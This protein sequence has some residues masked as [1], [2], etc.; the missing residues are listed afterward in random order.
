MKR[1]TIAGGVLGAA[2]AVAPAFAQDAA[3]ARPRAA[4]ADMRKM[5]VELPIKKAIGVPEE[6]HGAVDMKVRWH[7]SF[8]AA[9]NAA[10]ASGRPVLLFQ[11]LG[12][13][14]DEFC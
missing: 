14:D 3:N 5:V 8:A 13:L 4:S 1:I 12:K 6:K 7:E 11:L 10:K 2:L 9:V